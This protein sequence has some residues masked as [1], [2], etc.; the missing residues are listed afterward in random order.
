MGARRMFSSF[1][2]FFYLFIFFFLFSFLLIPLDHSDWNKDDVKTVCGMGMCP[3]STKFKGPSP[4]NNTDRPGELV[5][6]VG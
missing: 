1:F 2:L 4:K 3:I 6:R 5:V